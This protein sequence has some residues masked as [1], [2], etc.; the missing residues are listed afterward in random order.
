[1]QITFIAVLMAIY[2]FDS[3]GTAKTP[4]RIREQMPLWALI[5]PFGWA[6]FWWRNRK[7]KHGQIN[8]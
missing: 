1:M 3:W 2:V 5:M 8:D 4:T 7:T 6:I